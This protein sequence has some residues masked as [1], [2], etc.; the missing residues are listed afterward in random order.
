[1][2]SRW[3][4]EARE[5]G[6]LVT[7]EG[8][9]F[10]GLLMVLA[11]Y[12]GWIFLTG[13]AV[14]QSAPPRTLLTV[15]GTA[16]TVPVAGL[17][18]AWLAPPALLA[19]ILVDRYLRNR[20]GNRPPNAYRLVAHPLLLLWPPAV[21]VA[22]AGAVLART[23][24]GLPAVALVAVAALYLVVRTVAF[25]YRVYSF[26]RPLLLWAVTGLASAS[27]LGGLLAAAPTGGPVP[28]L[29]GPTVDTWQAVAGSRSLAVAGA[30]TAV[31]LVGGY[32]LLQTAT[33]VV[34]RLRAPIHDPDKRAGQRYP[35][36][37]EPAA[38]PDT[39]TATVDDSP[40][41][42][43]QTRVFQSGG[44]TGEADPEDQATA[45]PSTPVD[46]ESGDSSPPPESTGRPGD[47]RSQATPAAE[48]SDR[49]ATSET[50]ASS[51]EGGSSDGRGDGPTDGSDDWEADTAVFTPGDTDDS[52]G[53]ACGD[54]GAQLADEAGRFC[55]NCGNQ[56][57]G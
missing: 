50:A 18:L 23:G 5:S 32:V 1:M 47:R 27:A 38:E 37:S 45:S 22:A 21:A 57:G 7:R 34:T 56:I 13:Y 31:V 33:G 52:D 20:S 25:G 26:S 4:A 16:V 11:G 29:V 49:G 14:D 53:V 30:G 46:E 39:P 10:A 6:V 12:A 28:I 8:R 24:P 2:T 51:D 35:P 43:S 44:P 48:S 19:P 36:G 41:A 17:T 54:C 42:P 55:P 15:R 3:W 40:E 9:L